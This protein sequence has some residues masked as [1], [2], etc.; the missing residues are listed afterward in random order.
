M[1]SDSSP[2]D[3]T[4]AVPLLEI[5]DL[6]DQI[7]MA[8]NDLDRLQRLLDDT[9]NTLLGDFY[10]ASGELK[11]LLH[12]EGEAPAEMKHVHQAM[13]YLFGA[14]TALQFQDLSTQLLN[15]TT[16]RLRHCADRL[17]QLGMGD[18]EEGAT[19]VSAPPSKPNPVT[20]DEMDTGSI[21]LF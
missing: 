17:A 4:A 14:V 6:H 15:H 19:V 3:L 5:A 20:Q 16:A 7:M 18:D 2:N 11:R 10:G 13:E 9:G 21:E 8:A 1:E 12:T